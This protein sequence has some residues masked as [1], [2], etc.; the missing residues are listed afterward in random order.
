MENTL[1]HDRITNRAM[2]RLEGRNI[3][4][5]FGLTPEEKIQIVA[6]TTAAMFKNEI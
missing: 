4:V 2:V 6:E 1:I 5:S 3:R